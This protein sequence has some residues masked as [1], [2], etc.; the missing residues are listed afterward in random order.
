MIDSQ[1][2]FHVEDN[3]GDRL[4]LTLSLEPMEVP[5]TIDVARDG[6]EAISRVEQWTDAALRPAL[7]VLDLNLPKRSGLEVLAAVRRYPDIPVIVLTS[8]SS[9]QDRDAAYEL[10]V[11]AYLTKPMDVDGFMAIGQVLRRFLR[12]RRNQ[13]NA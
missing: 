9:P 2:L 3:E 4:L 5:L 1:R 11:C 7:V 10:G 13:Q 8:S 6:E 12:S